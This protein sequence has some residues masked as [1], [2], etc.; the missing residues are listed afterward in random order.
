M[1]L[2]FWALVAARGLAIDSINEVDLSRIAV[3]GRWDEIPL[4]LASLIRRD[5]EVKNAFQGFVSAAKQCASNYPFFR[6]NRLNIRLKRFLA[7]RHREIFVSATQQ[8]FRRL[9]ELEASLEQLD[10][11]SLR[12]LQELEA[13]GDDLAKRI[14]SLTLRVSQEIRRREARRGGEAKRGKFDPVRQFALD[15]ANRGHFPSRRQAVLAI[16]GDVLAYAQT[17]DGLS[18][19][20]QQAEKT[21]D[22]WLRELGYTPSAS[23]QGTSTG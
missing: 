15:L 4:D 23:K 1:Y 19:S 11:L 8:Y 17:I 16:R 13:A 2:A 3:G 18:M 12:S 9:N 10:S 5:A 21:I 14:M 7:D 20:E 6:E 22:N